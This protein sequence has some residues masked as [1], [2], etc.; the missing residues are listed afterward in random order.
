MRDGEIRHTARTQWWHITEQRPA[1]RCTGSL[2]LVPEPGAR[3]LLAGRLDDLRALMQAYPNPA[4][5]ISS[6]GDEHRVP[7][8]HRV[9]QDWDAVHSRRSISVRPRSVA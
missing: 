4:E 8:W 9:A 1:D 7:S 6:D 3:V 2:T 5:E